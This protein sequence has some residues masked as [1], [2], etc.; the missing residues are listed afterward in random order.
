MFF[1]QLHP[2]IQHYQYNIQ[3]HSHLKLLLYTAVWT[4]AILSCAGNKEWCFLYPLVPMIRLL[5]ARSLVLL[6]DRANP[7]YSTHNTRLMAPI[8]HRYM[9][10]S[11]LVLFGALLREVGVEDVLRIQGSITEKY[12]GGVVG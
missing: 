5:A 4:S 9:W 2:Q 3:Q 6:Y 7:R 11:R 1:A 12:G 10:P 8:P